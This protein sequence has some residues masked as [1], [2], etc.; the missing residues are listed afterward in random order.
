MDKI[1]D[2]TEIISINDPGEIGREE[3]TWADRLIV[4]SSNFYAWIFPILMVAIVAQVFLRAAGHNQAWLDDLQWWL[5]GAAVLVAIAYAVTTDAH[6]R[7]DIFYANYSP[8]RKARINCFSLVWCFLPFIILCWD[9]TVHYAIA[10]VE[11]QEGSDSPNGLHNLWLLKVFMNLA[12][13]FIGISIWAAYYRNLRKLTEPKLWKQLF[14][15]FPSTMF[16]VNLAVFYALWWFYYLTTSGDEGFN[17]RRIVR[18]PIFESTIPITF[19]LTLVLIGL[20]WL[21]G[22]SRREI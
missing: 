18:E 6:V 19:V 16:L 9:V 7:V 2:V 13:V 15:A 21:V 17:F 10:S 1:T 20:A 22:R 14:W 5:Y 11:A 3:H 8:E 4:V 12:F